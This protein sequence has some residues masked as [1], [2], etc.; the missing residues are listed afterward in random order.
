MLT[1]LVEEAA[2]KTI[3][4]GD[5]MP[6]CSFRVSAPSEEELMGQVAAHVREAHPEVTLTPDLVD[7]VRGRIRE[8]PNPARA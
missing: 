4:C 6:G 5:L 2:M 1:G 7:A 3:A 8:E